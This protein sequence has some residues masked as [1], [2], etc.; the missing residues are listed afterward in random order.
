MEQLKP[1]SRVNS[2]AL[3]LTENIISS[4]HVDCDVRRSM[5]DLDVPLS[6]VNTAARVFGVDMYGVTLM[7]NCHMP[8]SPCVACRKVTQNTDF[9]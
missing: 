5:L 7:Q 3:T 2:A 8:K 9:E 6:I 4:D 1:E